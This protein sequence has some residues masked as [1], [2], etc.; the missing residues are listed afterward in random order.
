MDLLPDLPSLRLL[1][2]VAALGGIGAA[3]RAAGISQQSAS[4]RLRAVETRTGLVL[5]QRAPSGSTLTAAGRLLVEWSR[6]LLEQ[7]DDVEE[8]LRTLR[9]ERSL[10]LHVHASMTTAEHLAPRWLVTLRRERGTVASLHATNTRSVLEAVRAGRADIGLIEGP[11]DLAGLASR[12][13]GRDTLVL[14]AEPGHPWTRRR[15]PVDVVEVAASGLTGREQGSGTRL[16]LEDAF[17]AAGHVPPVPEV[18]LTTNA[19]VLASV[20]AGS[21]PAFVSDRAARGEVEAGRLAEV[22]TDGL[23]LRR[24]FTA[25]WVGASRPPAGPVRDLLGIAGRGRA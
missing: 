16:V 3:G 15:R 14:L 7:A 6:P 22:A 24:T 11:A 17:R 18:E 23:D 12:V 10:E 19:A 13:V 1:A 8:A 25:V 20:R 21:P 2:D 9:E 5:V 4:E